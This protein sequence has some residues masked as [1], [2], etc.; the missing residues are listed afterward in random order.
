MNDLLQELGLVNPGETGDPVEL[1]KN[2][3]EDILK[4]IKNGYDTQ[5][6]NSFVSSLVSVSRRISDTR[7]DACKE[8]VYSSNLPKCSVVIP[9]HNEDWSL[10]MRTIHSVMINSPPELIEEIVL[11]DDASDRGDFR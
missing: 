6:Y 10:L 5:G 4:L 2:L 3:S 11:C 9:F 8:F 1:P 7:S